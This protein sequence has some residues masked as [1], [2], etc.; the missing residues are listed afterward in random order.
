MLRKKILTAKMKDENFDRGRGLNLGHFCAMWGKYYSGQ[1]CGQSF[2]RVTTQRMADTA[3]RNAG[4]S[5]SSQKM[6]VFG[7]TPARLLAHSLTPWSSVLEDLTAHQ[8]V[9]KFPAFYA[10]QR[11]IT[12]FTSARH[13]SLSWPRSIQSIHP[14]PTSWR[15]ILI[16]SSHLRFGRPSGFLPVGLPTKILYIP[17]LYPIHAT[18]P[19]HLILDFITRTI[20]GEE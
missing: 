16:L 19:A 9:K 13:L 3:I 8:L 17:L 10:T 18:Y 4:H 1:R 15:P 5:A 6:S 12:A 20:S 14:H 7:K 2:G 11:F